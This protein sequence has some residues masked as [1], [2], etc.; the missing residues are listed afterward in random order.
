M[1]R[2][3]SSINQSVKSKK[4]SNS[5]QKKKTNEFVY[6]RGLKNNDSLIEKIKTSV[7]HGF[8]RIKGT[9]IHIFGQVGKARVP[10]TYAKNPMVQ[11]LIQWGSSNKP[12]VIAGCGLIL[13]VGITLGF[14]SSLNKTVQVANKP[15][16]LPV[17]KNV[18]TQQVE[19]VKS[20]MFD[21]NA[22]IKGKEAYEATESERIIAHSKPGYKGW[23]ISVSNNP[24]GLFK[25]K[26]EADQVLARYKVDFGKMN[27][28]AEILKVYFKE[29]VSVIDY[30]KPVGSTKGYSNLDD[31]YMYLVKGSME[32]RE[33]VVADGETFWDIAVKNQMSVEKL[34][35]ANPQIKPEL[36]QIG[37]TLN[38]ISPK[39]LLTVCV[40]EKATLQEEIPFEITYK[41]SKTLYK[42]DEA[43]VTQGKNGERIV[44]ANV[45]KENG[46]IVG[47]QVLSE[48]ILSNPVIK[49]VQKGTKVKPS[50]APTGKFAKPIN[51][52]SFSSDFGIRWGRAHTGVDVSTQPGA[53]IYAADG[54]TVTKASRYDAYGICIII[55]HDNGY[56]TYYAHLSKVMVKA[57]D[58]VYKGQE[59]GLSGQTGRV[60]GPHLHFEVRRYGVPT[61][62]EKYVKFR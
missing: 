5:A 23:S 38:L 24:I 13:A 44:V 42:G 37:D 26:S 62:P 55:K 30:Y 6:L 50:T 49:V 3:K 60:T 29:K 61:D 25:T 45:T 52:G 51:R 9:V 46:I 16:A 47:K 19:V 28:D 22:V 57:G 4:Y 15:S 58:K 7:F 20:I 10:H 53:P 27:Q 43:V 59:I 40:V 11:S 32:E 36:L 18:Q 48:K 8:S 33:H 31:A 14:M 41:D 34:L 17:G 2:K 56:E 54:G 1:P 35:E 21:A 12:V 39:P